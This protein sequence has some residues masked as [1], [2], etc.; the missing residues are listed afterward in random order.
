[1]QASL[2][3]GLSAMGVTALI[4]A[5]PTGFFWV[6]LVG[7]G[8]LVCLGMRGWINAGRPVVTVQ[9]SGRRIYSKA[10]MIA[11]INAKSVAGYLAA[12][13]QFVQP[14]VPIWQQMQVTVPTAL[15]IRAIGYTGYTALARGRDWPRWGRC[16][17][18]CLTGCFAA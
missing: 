7:A 18:G 2:F 1:M 9:V 4:I 10:F 11:T 8:F 6:K 14:D 3:L 15:V 12:F 16:L 17:T 5:S 13:S